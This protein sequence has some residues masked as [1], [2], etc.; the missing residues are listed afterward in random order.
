MVRLG[1]TTAVEALQPL[2]SADSAVVRRDAVAALGRLKQHE[3][4]PDLL[5][6]W[7]R[8]DTSEVAIQALTEVP[9]VRALDAY[10]AGLASTNSSLREKCRSAVGSI[11]AEALPMLQQRREEVAPGVL[12]ELRRV[13]AKDSGALQSA[14]FASVPPP[15]EV[16]EYERFALT[17][18]GDPRRGQQLFF[19]VNGVACLRCHAV[20]GEG[21]TVGPDLTTIGSQFGRAA[22]IES[23]LYPSKVVREGYQQYTIGLVDEESITGALRAESADSLTIVDADGGTHELKKTRI[24]E[25]RASALSLMP[26][27]LYATLT[28]NQFADLIAYVESLRSDPRRNDPKL[29]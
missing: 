22:L 27:G 16:T 11:A 10:L 8:P 4:V 24:K 7:Q 26:E 18:D 1:G 13:Y 29:P 5:A 3:A 25:R 20:A 14:L 12:S 17:H 28:L 15:P 21:G 6:S 9:D 2:L 19:N 23:I